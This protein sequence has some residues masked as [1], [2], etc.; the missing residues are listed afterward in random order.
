MIRSIGRPGYAR[1]S[2]L[3]LAAALSVAA[4]AAPA[5][6]AAGLPLALTCTASWTTQFAPG[7]LLT[8]SQN[9]TITSS[10]GTLASCLD[11]SG[12]GPS[13]ITSGTFTVAGTYSG[14]CLTGSAT[15][16]ITITWQLAD[17]GTASSTATASATEAA[18]AVLSQLAIT[19]GRLHGDT[20]T[21]ANVRTQENALDCLTTGL[22]QVA[23][24]GA[25]LV[26]AP[27]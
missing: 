17:G 8:T 7:V 9:G 22:T 25:V 21:V 4:T 26:T 6:H 13:T 16:T 19:G 2:G 3:L 10:D 23:A 24:T 20:M 1:W 18:V 15:E 5:A 12:Q 14:T 11:T 27:V